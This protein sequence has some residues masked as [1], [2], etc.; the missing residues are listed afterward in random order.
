MSD[1][2][3]WSNKHEYDY[4]TKERVVRVVVNPQWSELNKDAN[5]EVLVA[6]S[7][8]H[9]PLLLATNENKLR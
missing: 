4:F 3:T 9:T 2:F 7:S 1:K 5:I 6:R 8:Y